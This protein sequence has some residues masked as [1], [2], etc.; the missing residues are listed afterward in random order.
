MYCGG[1][2]AIDGRGWLGSS[3]HRALPLTKPIAP[4]V[5]EQQLQCGKIKIVK[6]F[7]PP[8]SGRFQISLTVPA[9]ARAAIYRLTSKVAV[10]SHAVKHGFTT[11]SLPLPVA[12]G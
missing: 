11:F 2:Y 7:T 8:A 3:S 9:D 10:N 12:I 1:A 5:V 4:I 6:S